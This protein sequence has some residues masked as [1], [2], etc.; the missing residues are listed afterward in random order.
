MILEDEGKRIRPTVLRV[1][2]NIKDKKGGVLIGKKGRCGNELLN[3]CF[4]LLKKNQTDARRKRVK[5]SITEHNNTKYRTVRT[6]KVNTQGC[7]G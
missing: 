2:D 1:T 6:T 5:Q 4:L 7:L 3:C